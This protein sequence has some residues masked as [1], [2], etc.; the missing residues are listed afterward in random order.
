MHEVCV[1]LH[2]RPQGSHQH[3][4]K[5]LGLVESVQEPLHLTEWREGDVQVV[6]RVLEGVL[7]CN[8]LVWDWG[9]LQGQLRVVARGNRSVAKP[10]QFQ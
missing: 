1:P 9:E 4:E 8:S 10:F 5:A 3:H 6:P 7:H 2:L